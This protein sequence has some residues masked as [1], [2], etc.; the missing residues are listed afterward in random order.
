[1]GDAD[2]TG[3]VFVEVEV[4]GCEAASLAAKTGAAAPKVV[5]SAG[6]ATAL[7]S[8]G[9]KG[10]DAEVEE[11]TI[12]GVIGITAVAGSLGTLRGCDGI[13][14]VLALVE[15]VAPA[16]LVA[17]AGCCRC[18]PID[19]AVAKL[20]AP[21]LPQ[22]EVEKAPAALPKVVVEAVVPCVVFAEEDE[23]E[24]ALPEVEVWVAPCVVAFAGG[25]LL[26]TTTAAI[27]DD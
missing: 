8:D 4:E 17:V 25:A 15:K 6:A 13:V 20:G 9:F 3:V 11:E 23:A 19:T 12:A 1:M 27:P 16:P 2:A 10:N 18:W 22:V 14:L 5:V 7:P 24:G 26:F 21:A